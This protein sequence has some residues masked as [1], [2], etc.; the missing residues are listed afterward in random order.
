MIRGLRR[1]VTGGIL[2]VQ[3][4]TLVAQNVPVPSS[5]QD[6]YSSLD[7]KLSAFESM[8]NSQWTGTN[9]PVIFGAELLTANANRGLQLLQPNAQTSIN[10]ELDRLQSLGVQS[11]TIAIGF[12]I[13]YQPFFQF[14]G[15]PA[16]YQR[17]ID[18]Y[19]QLITNIHNRGMKVIVENSVL[20]TGFYSQNS[21]FKLDEYYKTLTTADQLIAGRAQTAITIA[22]EVRPDFLNLGSEPDTQAEAHWAN[23]LPHAFRLQRRDQRHCVPSTRLRSIGCSAG[24]RSRNLV[25]RRARIY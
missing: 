22:K 20:F 14:N 19:K 24:S 2:V 13:L 8:V 23:Y 12:P 3:A 18:F 25:T 7:S 16:D 5:F 4:A 6:L 9:S 10:L 11:V 15:N 17:F 1:L 21:G